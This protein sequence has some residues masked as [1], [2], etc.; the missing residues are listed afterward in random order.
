MSFFNYGSKVFHKDTGVGGIVR[1]RCPGTLH[2]LVGI[3]WDDPDTVSA[4]TPHGT[5]KLS[6]VYCVPANVLTTQPDETSAAE[7][8]EEL[9]DVVDD[10]TDELLDLAETE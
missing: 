4:A 2:S 7:N 8:L 9:S 6:G 1:C 3:L 10:F 5:Q